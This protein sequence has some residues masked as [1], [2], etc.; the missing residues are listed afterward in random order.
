MK[1][2]S[3]K[4]G[5]IEIGDHYKVILICLFLTIAVF[6]VYWQAAGF[7]FVNFDDPFYVKDNSVVGQGLTL[8]GI[9]W[10]FTSL[11]VSNWH[12]LTWISHM[13]DVQFFG[14]TPGLHHLTNVVIHMLNTILLFILFKNMTG[15]LWRSA[16]VAALFALHP[17]HVESVAWISER[18]DVLS[19]LFWILTVMG[20]LWYI[21]HRSI[22]RY[23]VVVALY[24][25]GLMSKPMLVT[26]PFVL[27]LLDF[28]PLNR[29]DM[30]SDDSDNHN[31]Y[32]VESGISWYKV[33]FLVTEKI[34]L[35]VLA[36]ISSSV[37]FFAQQTGG[38][39][40]S[41][42]TI[43][44]GTRI[45][46]AVISYIAYIEKMLLPLNL[47]AFYPYPR[48]FH[49]PE[50]ILCILLLLM[51]TG[52]TL[53]FARKLP[54]LVV[55]WF[56]YLGTLVPVIGIV[57]VGAQSM[58]DRYT[59][60]PLVGIFLMVVWSIADLLIQWRYG[61]YALGISF[62]SVL[63]LL[64]W[65]SWTQTGYW[66]SSETL[67]RHALDVTDN[68]D[69]AHYNLGVAL[70]D[71][72][73]N[74]G[75][76]KQYEE[77]LRINQHNASAHTNL[78]NLLYLKGNADDAIGHY[79]EALKID[80]HKADVY[81]NLGTVYYHKGNIHKAIQCFEIA[82]KEKP[83]YIQAMEK[84]ETAKIQQANFPDP[85]SSLQRSIMQ[86]PSNPMLYVSLGDAYR[87]N[88]E[89][90]EAIAQY[91]KAVSLQPK[92]IEAMYGLVLSYSSRQDYSKAVVELQNIR[93]LQPDNPEVYYNIACMYA[94]QNMTD[95][96]VAWLKQSINKG[97]HDWDLLKKDPDLANIRNTAFVNELIKNSSSQ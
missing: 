4:N 22:R 50:I 6:A 48:T 64:M 2:K 61:R 94:K 76:M 16:A 43:H 97:F 53:M 69:F 82:V 92:M 72:G 26:L 62:A 25:F 45:T 55:G 56:W 21:N 79:L 9:K 81:Y 11:Y 49:L 28:W 5:P 89:Y 41:G 31:S 87:Q 68:N 57:Q 32:I 86:D 78:G 30:R 73:D 15:A 36:V 27:L 84:L 88:G 34:P 46:N 19:T 54:S 37:T 96:S 13:L 77:S 51:I 47:A 90:N 44:L 74:S 80:P 10:A 67:F 60:I 24:I 3:E 23:L 59:Y 38:S 93:H 14:M 35:I 66:K 7:D 18:K 75:A 29:L 65:A 70:F 40:I 39:V 42:Q 20:Y 71:K 17:L 83:G 85:I 91:Q 58:S 52:F 1:I 33:S 12:P 63:A 95:E 8:D